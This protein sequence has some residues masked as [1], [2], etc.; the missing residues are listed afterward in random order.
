MDSVAQSSSASRGELFSRVAERMNIFPGLVEKDFWVC[1]V[2]KHLYLHHD[3]DGMQVMLF[4]K[5][6]TFT[7]ILDGIQDLEKAIRQMPV[8]S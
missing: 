8:E 3:Y 2:L 5:S 7:Q 4:G 6:P 1:W